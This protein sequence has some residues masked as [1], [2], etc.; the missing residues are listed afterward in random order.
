[1]KRCYKCGEEKALCEFSKNKS[2]KDG[3][4]SLCKACVKAYYEANKEKIAERH[5]AYRQANKDKIA[6]RHKA[7]QQAKKKKRLLNRGKPTAKQT[8]IRLLKRIKPTHKQTKRQ[9][10]C[11]SKEKKDN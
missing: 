5:K 6:K 8:K 1:M 10:E 9:E 4:N 7:Y 2:R 3:L 11:L